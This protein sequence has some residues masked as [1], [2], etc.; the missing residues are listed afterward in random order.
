MTRQIV[1]KL[2]FV[3][4]SLFLFISHFFLF[5]MITMVNIYTVIMLYYYCL[6]SYVHISR[7]GQISLCGSSE[8]RIVL[9]PDLAEVVTGQG[10]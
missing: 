9:G 5:Q 1:V 4:V 3:A 2:E 10:S 8:V 7:H 6:F